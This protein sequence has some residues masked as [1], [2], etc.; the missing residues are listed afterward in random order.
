MVR[1][2]STLELFIPR[3]TGPV[4]VLTAPVG[5]PQGETLLNEFVFSNGTLYPPPGWTR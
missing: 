3:Q 4:N 1:R 2:C 5:D